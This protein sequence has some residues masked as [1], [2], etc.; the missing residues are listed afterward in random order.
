MAKMWFDMVRG[1]LGYG[2]TTAQVSVPMEQISES[3]EVAS[4]LTD[5]PPS[6][7]SVRFEATPPAYE[8]AIVMK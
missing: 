2:R 3:E 8:S 4:N 6:Y 7:I 1:T 5:N